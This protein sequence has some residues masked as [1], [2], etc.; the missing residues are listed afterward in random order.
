MEVLCWDHQAKASTQRLP[1]IS[2]TITHL[3]HD[4][5]QIACNLTCRR[6][7]HPFANQVSAL[8]V[9]QLPSGKESKHCLEHLPGTKL[10]CSPGQPRW[11]CTRRQMHLCMGSSPD[12]ESLQPTRPNTIVCWQMPFT[13][14]LRWGRHSVRTANLCS[15]FQIN[16]CSLL[17]VFVSLPLNSNSSVFSSPGPQ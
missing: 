7:R 8:P 4:L 6:T 16:F 14:G 5:G 11:H 13:S 15:S 17:K 3:L 12:A 10:Y 2:D 9:F 1:S